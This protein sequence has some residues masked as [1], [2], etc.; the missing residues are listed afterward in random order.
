MEG[1]TV[2]CVEQTKHKN[3]HASCL[4]HRVTSVVGEQEGVRQAHVLGWSIYHAYLIKDLY[5]Y[6]FI[7]SYLTVKSGPCVPPQTSQKDYRRIKR[8]MTE[9]MQLILRKIL[10]IMSHS[11]VRNILEFLPSEPITTKK[12]SKP[13]STQLTYLDLIPLSSRKLDNFG[14]ALVFPFT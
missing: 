5:S 12:E 6:T 4:H 9:S 11:I 2:A 8:E 13:I 7:L 1:A 14:C 10:C 3:P